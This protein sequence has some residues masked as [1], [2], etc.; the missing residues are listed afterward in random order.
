MKSRERILGFDFGTARIGIAVGNTITCTAEPLAVVASGTGGPD[1]PGIE[2]IIGQ[3]NPRTLIVGLP[4][5]LCGDETAS[6]E[7]VRRFARQLGNRTGLEVRLVDERLTTREATDIIA[8]NTASGI[9][10]RKNP[11]PVDSV[12]AQLILETY[13]EESG[14]PACA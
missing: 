14:D 7:K 10:G 13:F 6:S 12:A 4:I 5:S 9:S 2:K 1:W 3:W 8:R 11:P